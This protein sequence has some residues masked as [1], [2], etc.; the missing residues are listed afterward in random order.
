MTP[1][2]TNSNS[3]TVLV[4]GA[5][6]NT[7][8]PLVKQLLARGYNLRIIV[9]SLDKF[10]QE[11]LENSKLK[12]IKASLLDL[13]DEQMLEAVKGCGAVASCLGHTLSFKGM[14]GEPRALVLEAVKRLCVV[15]TA[16]RFAAKTKFLLMN[17]VGNRNPGKRV[18]TGERFILSLLRNLI[19]PHYDNEASAAFLRDDI[20]SENEFI[21]WVV[22]RPDGLINAEISNYEVVATPPRTIFNGLTATR[23]TVAHFMCECIEKPNLW[24][25]WKGKMPV[26]FN[27]KVK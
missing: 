3:K 24:L 4:V 1:E 22:V 7:G 19:P 11:L 18:I 9:R 27:K 8:F 15:I 13:S 17:T 10:P 14:F 16:T 5:T 6:G 21:E 23:A 25:Q 2:K 12:I 20:G 26:V